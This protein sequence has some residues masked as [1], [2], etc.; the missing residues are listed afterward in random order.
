MN[1]SHHRIYHQ[2]RCYDVAF[3]FRDVSAE[4]D[5]L[6][7]L[8]SRHSGRPVATVLELA[9]GP[10]R[11]AREFARR[12]AAATALDSSSTMCDY[13]LE[14]AAHDG[15]HLKAVAA[16]MRDFKLEQRFDLTALLMN[17]SSYLLDNEAVLSHLACVARANVKFRSRPVARR[18]NRRRL[19]WVA[20]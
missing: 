5:T 13:A 14:R 4:C 7:A 17:S 12:G 19:Q 16:D 8:A 10:A 11:H 3:G 2:A 15:L 6:A 1:P 18:E 9:A 20:A